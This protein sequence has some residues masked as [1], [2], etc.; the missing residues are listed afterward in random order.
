M[1]SGT[2]TML[3]WGYVIESPSTRSSHAPQ[4]GDLCVHCIEKR[5]V[6]HLRVQG[7]VARE[8]SATQKATGVPHLWSWGSGGSDPEALQAAKQW[9]RLGGDVR[10]RHQ[11]ML[12]V[13]D[14]VAFYQIIT[15]PPRRAISAS[16]AAR[17]ARSPFAGSRVLWQERCQP[18]RRLQGY[19]TDGGSWGSGGNHPEALQAAKQW[20]RLGG[21]VQ[22]RQQAMLGGA[23]QVHLLLL[24]IGRGR[25]LHRP[26]PEHV[27]LRFAFGD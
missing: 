5:P 8:M 2:D 12:G 9:F 14:Q 26:V 4:L 20:F 10:H 3:C 1:T 23:G 22:H 15:R 24:G 27:R 17:S 11:A 19:L 25:V 21:D 18:P 13:C 7:P 16:T 6:A